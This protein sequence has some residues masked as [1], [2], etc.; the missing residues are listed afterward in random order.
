M[1]RK[2]NMGYAEKIIAYAHKINKN[3]AEFTVKD[4]C[5][6]MKEWMRPPTKQEIAKMNPA[7]RA[8]YNKDLANMKK[9]REEETIAKKKKE[10]MMKNT[11]VAQDEVGVEE[12]E[13]VVE[14]GLVQ[15]DVNALVW[16]LQQIYENYELEGTVHDEP[17]KGLYS[18]LKDLAEE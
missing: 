11:E 14:M 1:I 2:N 17:L 3:T 5:A 10:D 6:F 4:L 13:I 8:E 16:A 9:W 12:A 15:A 7:Q 18:G